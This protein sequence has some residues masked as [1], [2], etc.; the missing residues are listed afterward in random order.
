MGISHLWE[1]VQPAHQVRSLSQLT[2]SEGFKK[3]GNGH[4]TIMLGVDAS[5]WLH[6]TQAVFHHPR[7]SQTG[8][9]PE[10]WTL[11]HKLNRFLNQSVSVVFVFD[12][13]EW[14]SMKHRKHVRP[15]EHWLAKWFREFAKAFGFSTHIAPGK[16][17][18]E[19]ALLN[20]LGIIDIVVTDDSD[21]LIFGATCVMRNWNIKKNKDDVKLYTSEGIQTIASVRLT[22]GGML[23]I[24]ILCGGD[25]DKLLG[26]TKDSSEEDLATFLV[27]WRQQL[28][29]ELSS[30]V[31]GFLK[32]QCPTLANVVHS[33]FPQPSV[34]LKYTQPITSWAGGRPLPLFSAWVHREPDLAEMASLAER[35]FSWSPDEIMEKFQTHMWLGLCLCRLLKVKSPLLELVDHVV[36]GVVVDDLPCLSSF[37]RINCASQGTLALPVPFFDIKFLEQGL[38]N[39]ARSKLLN[40]AD[41]RAKKMMIP[42]YVEPEPLLKVEEEDFAGGFSSPQPQPVILDYLDLTV[43]DDAPSGVPNCRHLFDGE[44]IDLTLD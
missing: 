16:A 35:S 24:A 21:A 29:D 43:D 1:I 22:Q 33:D 7:H 3:N 44:V 27:P 20:K 2:L 42:K 36:H 31:Q 19:L 25:Y 10:L 40:H 6:Q 8:K 5:I 26:A 11:F 23:L 34:I 15:R 17:K 38:V 12:G 9:N 32:C 41:I 30:N 39:E 37:L 14:P 13:S 28:R 18:A 4:R